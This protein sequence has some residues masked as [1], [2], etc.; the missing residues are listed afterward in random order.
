MKSYGFS[1]G[2]TLITLIITILLGKILY[3]NVMIKDSEIKKK[4]IIRALLYGIK[5]KTYIEKLRKFKSK[6]KCV[7]ILNKIIEKQ[8]ELKGNLFY[9]NLL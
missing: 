6:F 7:Q 1:F 8:K 4:Y 5:E 2:G 3:N 9:F